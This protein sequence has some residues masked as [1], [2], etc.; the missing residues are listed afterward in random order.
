MTRIKWQTPW[1]L[2]YAEKDGTAVSIPA[3]VPGNALADIVRAGLMPDPF[4]GA[5]SL[6][7]RKFDY[8]DFKYTSSF[9]TP[10]FAPGE[11]VEI[12]FG[13]VD[14]VADYYLDGELIGAVPIVSLEDVKRSGYGD[15]FTFL[16]KEFLF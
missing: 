6:E 11:T 13:G 16:I 14:T 7:F 9:T 4:F 5:N 3:Q 2:E 15:F 10:D 8:I 1:Q 12:V